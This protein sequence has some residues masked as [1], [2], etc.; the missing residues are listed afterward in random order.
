M[1]ISWM[2]RIASGGDGARSCC[3]EENSKNFFGT[4]LRPRIYG[5]FGFLIVVAFATWK[6]S[7]VGSSVERLDTAQDSAMR[8]LEIANKLQIIRRADLRYIVD[9]D[10][11]SS[12]EATAAESEAI[13]LWKGRRLANSLEIGGR[14]TVASEPTWRPCEQSAL[15]WLGS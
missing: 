13:D 11:E 14:H 3:E 10:Q 6:L 15:H 1:E 12:R 5:G 8:A 7:A 4:G 9:A 2:M